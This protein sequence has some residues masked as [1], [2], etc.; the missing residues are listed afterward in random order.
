MLDGSQ[1][2]VTKNLGRFEEQFKGHGFYRVHHKHLINLA[3]LSEVNSRDNFLRLKNG[4]Q[5]NISSRKKP[6]FLKYLKD[7]YGE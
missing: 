5:V 7:R 1:V 6:A 2:A 3:H 4:Q